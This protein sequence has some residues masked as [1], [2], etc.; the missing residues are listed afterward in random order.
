MRPYAAPLIDGRLIQ[1]IERGAATKTAAELT[2]LVGTAAWTFGLVRPSYQQV[3]VIRLRY[4]SRPRPARG[5]STLS[6]A[7]DVMF[8]VRPGYDLVDYLADGYLPYRR[9]AVNLPRRGS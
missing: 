4:T 7:L 2:R 1:L 5:V 6:V 9:G 8:R 3:R